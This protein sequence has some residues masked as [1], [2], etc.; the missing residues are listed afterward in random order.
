[1]SALVQFALL[2]PVA[3]HGPP[4]NILDMRIRQRTKVLTF[5]VSAASRTEGG[6][7]RQG[8]V[9][10]MVLGAGSG[11]KGRRYAVSPV[12]DNMGDADDEAARLAAR[13]KLNRA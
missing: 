13:E 10:E 1:M 12:F 8:W 3:F 9:V 6:L 7:T 5:A 4:N 2:P 11:S